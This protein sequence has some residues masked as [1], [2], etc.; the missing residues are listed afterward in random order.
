MEFFQ[1]KLFIG[2][3]TSQRIADLALSET[4]SDLLAPQEKPGKA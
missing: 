4:R 3:H 2:G 1:I